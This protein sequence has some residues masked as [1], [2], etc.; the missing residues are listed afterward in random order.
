M[1]LILLGIPGSGKGSVA[2]LLTS[3]LGVPHIA[4]GDILRQE[5]RQKSQ[6]G[7]LAK[8][9]ME[10]GELVPDEIILKVMEKRLNQPDSRKGF[11]L[12]GFPRTLV[13]A[14]RLDSVLDGSDANLD[15]V[16]KFEVSDQ[17]AMKRLSGRQ[18][19]SVCGAIYNLYQ[20]PP[21]RKDVCDICGGTLFQ[22]A[23]DQ[24]DVIRNRLQVYRQRTQP[25]EQ[26]YQRQQKLRPV[27][28][29]ANPYG[30]LQEILAIVQGQ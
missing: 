12:D 26:Y 17:T 1:N 8:S 2:E 20:R 28:G 19:C 27:D 16:I 21:K 10:K 25:I 6:L 23:D 9:F 5:L 11:I 22:R 30:V 4:P 7:L 3:E 18:T 14:Q 29:E 15:F 24:E 13:Q